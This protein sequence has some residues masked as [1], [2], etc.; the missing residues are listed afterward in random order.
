MRIHLSNWRG[1]Y[2]VASVARSQ[3]AS[4]KLKSEQLSHWLITCDAVKS[5]PGDHELPVSPDDLE[6]LQALNNYDVIEVMTDGTVLRL[7]EDASTENLIFVTERCNSNCIMCPSPTLSRKNGF[8]TPVG[9]LMNLVEHIPSDATHLTIT[10]GEPF[11]IG[12]EIFSVFAKLRER[13]EGTEFLI[14]TN[15]RALALKQFQDELLQTVP[16]NTM[17]GIPIHASEA[18]LHDRITQAQGSFQQTVAGVDFLLCNGMCVELRIVVSRL[19]VND[20]PALAMMIAQRF[21]SVEHVSVMAMEMTGS[22][23]ENREEVWIPYRES[24]QA[25][26]KAVE[27]LIQAGINV[28]LFNYPLCAVEPK[29]WPLCR[30]SISPEKVRFAKVCDECKMRP[31]CGGVFGG[32]LLLEKAEL[33]PVV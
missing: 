30:K 24:F 1:K 29:Y 21:S 13:C 5:W 17:F 33:E 23:H 32:T 10:G 22:A 14:L 11:L 9:V 20:L 6:Q 8:H 4:D 7:Y 28:M 19:N 26:S 25:V 18:S 2:T 12:R 16:Y 27:I 31:S 3:V 15:G